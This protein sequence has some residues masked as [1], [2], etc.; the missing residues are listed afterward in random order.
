MIRSSFGRFALPLSVAGLA[1]L[2][3]LVVGPPPAQAQERVLPGEP[4]NVRLVAGDGKLTLTW[5]APSSW[6]SAA[7]KG[8]HIDVAAG[9]FYGS[10]NPPAHSHFDWEVLASPGPTA[11]SY[12]FTGRIFGNSA[13]HS[14]RHT[15]TNGTNYHF[16]IRAVSAPA[17]DPSDELPSF[18]VVKSGAPVAPGFSVTPT[19]LTV[20]VGSRA[21][22]LVSPNTLPTAAVSITANTAALS[23][24]V[25][26]STVTYA[27]PFSPQTSDW[28]ATGAQNRKIG[29]AFCVKGVTITPSPV[30][31]THTASSTD[32]DYNGI[33]VPSVTVT[34][35]AAD[36]TPV[37]RFLHSSMRV[38]EGDSSLAS[39]YPVDNLN[40]HRFV[41][42]LDIAPAPSAAGHV[43]WHVPHP[44]CNG[45]TE[46]QFPAS[47]STTYNIDYAAQWLLARRVFYSAGS[48]DMQFEFLIRADDFPE[49]DETV[50]VYLLDKSFEPGTG[51]SPNT[52]VCVGACS[53]PTRAQRSVVVTIIDDDAG[54]PECPS[55]GREGDLGRIAIPIQSQERDLTPEELQRQDPPVP[56]ANRAPAVSSPLSDATITNEGGTKTISLSGVFA[57]PD[58]DA[59]TVS[60]A[61]SNSAVAM[62]SVAAGYTSLTVSA[63]S[64]GTATIRVT[65]KDAFG[66]RAS[67]AFKVTVTAPQ[68][69]LSGI[70]AR[71]DANGDG[72]ID[73]SEYQQVKHDWLSG[74]IS[75]EEFLVVVR[76]HLRSG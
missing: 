71:Y 44:D 15:V 42:R 39:P 37:V 8:Y 21:C 46:C 68:A 43:I 19:S 61:S 13:N 54:E 27:T 70:A 17:G 6:G 48:N 49:E 47:T 56:L 72:A 14:Y 59:L 2:A 29:R 58:D 66:N 53:S 5:I 74:R 16:R 32:T 31:I 38:V 55:C 33:T 41:V 36:S 25:G 1:V 35:S 65:A 64:R 26:G 34:V 4:Q 67:D 45:V 60:A 73:G 50:T 30:T 62:V 69:N 51:F 9:R 22:Y 63:R 24:E 28:A 75:Y 23:T 76:V 3:M 11:T 7:A 57:D 10:A 18:W 12:T 20:P 52:G 40:L